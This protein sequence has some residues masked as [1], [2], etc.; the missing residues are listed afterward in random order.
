MVA[1]ELM[2]VCKSVA[3]HLFLQLAGPRSCLS[4]RC[5]CLCTG[6]RQLRRHLT[7]G[8]FGERPT[9]RISRKLLLTASDA[10][11][12]QVVARVDHTKDQRHQKHH[13]RVENVEEPLVVC[14]TVVSPIPFLGTSC[15]TTSRAAAQRTRE[16]L[17][18]QISRS[19][20]GEFD[21]SQHRTNEDRDVGDVDHL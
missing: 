2:S 20:R 14:I 1:Q 9:I 11:I 17:T 12:R 7:P 13:G 10:Q 16:V 8:Q 18:V 19:A 21:E 15:N 6:S 3:A 4:A 5:S